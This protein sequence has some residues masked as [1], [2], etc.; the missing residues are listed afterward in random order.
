MQP[1]R[2]IS[3]VPFLRQRTDAPRI[4]GGLR[5]SGA[6][7]RSSPCHGRTHPQF[8]PIFRPTTDRINPPWTTFSLS[9]GSSLLFHNLALHSTYPTPCGSLRPLARP[10]RTVTRALSVQPAPESLEE[11]TRE[12]DPAIKLTGPL[13]REPGNPESHRVD[14]R[15]VFQVGLF[16][17][18]G[19][20]MAGPHGACIVSLVLGR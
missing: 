4:L 16:A 19:R 10:L 8:I 11:R 20:K 18:L 5:S 13:C 15:F 7:G 9:T 6:A 3:D 2:A 14:S 1:I 17:P 12:W